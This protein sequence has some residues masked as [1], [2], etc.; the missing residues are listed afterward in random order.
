MQQAGFPYPDRT[1]SVFLTKGAC[2]KFE[3][4]GLLTTPVTR[5]EDLS[6]PS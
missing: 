4:L 3:E 2:P 6:S 5:D 1:F